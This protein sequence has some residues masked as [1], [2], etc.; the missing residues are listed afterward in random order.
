[1]KNRKLA[2]VLAMVL[3]ISVTGCGAQETVEKD[4]G[5]TKAVQESV[6]TTEETENIEST[7]NQPMAQSDADVTDGTEED[8]QY[9]DLGQLLGSKGVSSSSEFADNGLGGFLA[10]ADY[11]KGYLG[12][13]ALALNESLEE[14]GLSVENLSMETLEANPEAESVI[15]HFTMY[16]EE[17]PIIVEA[18]ENAFYATQLTYDDEIYYVVF[19]TEDTST[20][21]EIESYC[22]AGTELEY[23]AM[24]TVEDGVAILVPLF[25]GTEDL[26]YY[27]VRPILAASG[28]DMSEVMTLEEQGIDFGESTGAV[29]ETTEDTDED[30][31]DEETRTA[32]V[33]SDDDFGIEIG[34]IE[35]SGDSATV[36]YTITNNLAYDACMIDE[37]ILLNG[38]DITRDCIAV[39]KANS[40]ESL[41]D[42]FYIDFHEIKEGDIIEI[43]GTL[44]D[45]A[46]YEEKGTVSFT[47]EVQ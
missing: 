32:S 2:M 26:G 29:E 40:G 25:A 17:A 13:D 15:Y 38:E 16:N 47:I 42:V 10:G 20:E 45:E 1:M 28:I 23:W 31:D 34:T 11:E 41:D 18:D 12:K 7:E 9:Q 6:S 22:K 44:V 46:D 8:L 35:C 36:N 5:N 39:I 27:L 24:G 43:T 21:E 3:A 14:T 4:T 19:G 33:M 30:A 37:T